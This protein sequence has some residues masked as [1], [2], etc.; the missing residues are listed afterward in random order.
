MRLPVKYRYRSPTVFEFHISGKRKLTPMSSG[1][2][3]SSTMKKP[4]S[5]SPLADQ[6]SRMHHPE[7]SLNPLKFVHSLSIR[8][9]QLDQRSTRT[10][11]LHRRQRVKDITEE[12]CKNEPGLEDLKEVGRLPFRARF[13]AGTDESHEAFITD[14]DSRE[15]YEMER[16]VSQRAS[17]SAVQL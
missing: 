14:N 17:A 3:V 12:N 4:T 16:P 8:I 6:R 11:L 7:L 1:Y 2:T 15:T 9:G 13:K 5:T 10:N